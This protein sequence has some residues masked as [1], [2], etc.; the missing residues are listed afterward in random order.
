MVFWM[1]SLVF[2][3]VSKCVKR[4]AA[5]GR[6]QSPSPINSSASEAARERLSSISS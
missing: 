4:T 5:R 6:G 2:C 1:V 3:V